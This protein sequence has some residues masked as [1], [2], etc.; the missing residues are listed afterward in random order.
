MQW[1]SAW[2][3]DS[4]AVSVTGSQRAT[5]N[6][7]SSTIAGT[8]RPAETVRRASSA[9]RANHASES[10]RYGSP[11]SSDNHTAVPIASSWTDE[12]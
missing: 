9:M 7:P 2:M 3:V 4:I 10:D 1:V 8:M 12:A 11:G 6:G 5:V